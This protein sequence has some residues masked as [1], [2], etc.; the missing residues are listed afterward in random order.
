MYARKKQKTN[1]IT[2][3]HFEESLVMLSAVE[4]NLSISAKYDFK[5]KKD[6]SWKRR[7][8]FTIDIYVYQD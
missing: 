3:R 4:I 5:G 7:H 1:G 8:Q 6:L 2:D